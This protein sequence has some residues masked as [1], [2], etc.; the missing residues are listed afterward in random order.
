MM[1]EPGS[2]KDMA[3]L[4]VFGGLW[5]SAMAPAAAG[6]RHAEVEEYMGEARIAALPFK[7]GDRHDYQV[8]FGPSQMGMQWAHA[9]ATLKEPGRAL[10]ASRRAARKDLLP[11]SWGAMHLD[12]AQ[13]N[14]DMKRTPAAVGALLQALETGGQTWAS[15]QGQWRDLVA[16]AVQA[17]TRMSAGARKLAK[18][19]GIR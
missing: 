5:L 1:R 6:K 10:A 11:I 9:Y 12:V 3:H 18:A 4:T 17:E 16:D 14:L 13:A 7:Y 8:S 19:A 15:H 2:E